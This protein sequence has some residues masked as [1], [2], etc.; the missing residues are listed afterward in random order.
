MDGQAWTGYCG[1]GFA[2]KPCI[3]SDVNAEQMGRVIAKFG[4]DHPEKLHEKTFLFAAEALKSAFPCKDAG[5]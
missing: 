2:A 1:K 5:K 3:P 4:D